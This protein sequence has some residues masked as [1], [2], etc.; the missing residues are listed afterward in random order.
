MP[1]A[2]RDKFSAGQSMKTARTSKF[3]TM[4]FSELR[5][6]FSELADDAAAVADDVLWGGQDS[7]DRRDTEEE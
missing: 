5:L 4:P 6:R 1:P 2:F 7:T 3:A